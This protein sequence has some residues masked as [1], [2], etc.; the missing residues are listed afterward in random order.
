MISPGTIASKLELKI[1][2]QRLYETPSLQNVLLFILPRYSRDA[3]D[4]NNQ[5]SHDYQLK[6]N[7]L[8]KFKTFIHYSLKFKSKRITIWN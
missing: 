6:L 2:S 1:S 5:N 4:N 8:L 3:Y 7:Y